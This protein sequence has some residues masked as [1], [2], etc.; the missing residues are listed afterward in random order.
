[1]LCTEDETYPLTRSCGQQLG[2]GDWSGYRSRIMIEA[3]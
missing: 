1:M 2:K 3:T